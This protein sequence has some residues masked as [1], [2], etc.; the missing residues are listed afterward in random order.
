MK[1]HGTRKWKFCASGMYNSLPANDR[2][3]SSMG[4]CIRAPYNAFLKRSTYAFNETALCEVLRLSQIPML[5]K[6]PVD[7]SS[8]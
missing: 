6:S 5:I 1:E 3:L 4:P 8:D 7:L 2:L